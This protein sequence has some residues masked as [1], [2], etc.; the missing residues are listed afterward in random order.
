LTFAESLKLEKMNNFKQAIT[1][2]A[3]FCGM[4]VMAQQSVI[5]GIVIDDAT[6]ESLIGVAVVI[7]GTTIGDATDLE[8][9]FEIKAEPGTY[10]L[11]VAFISFAK[12]NISDVVVKS[13][14]VTALG[15]IRLKSASELLQEFVVTAKAVKNTEA[16]MVTMKQNSTSLMDGISA[17]SFKKVGDSDAAS[18]VT[19]VTGVSVQ[20]GKYVY[21]RGLGDRYTKTTLNGMDLPGLDPDRNSV[22]MDIFPTNV[23]DN[24]VV[25]KSFTADLPADFTG[26]AVNIELKDFPEE[27]IMTAGISTSYNPVMNLN[28][29]Y[30]TYNGG[31]TD[32]LGFDDG[33]RDIPT[34][35]QTDIPQYADPEVIGNPNSA[36]SQEFQTTLRSFDK[37]MGG[38]RTTSGLNGGFNFTYANKLK[39]KDKYAIG[40][41]LALNYQNTTEYYEGAEF[42]LYGKQAGATN[43]EL[44][45]LQ[46]Q[47]GDYGVNNVLLGGT[48]GLAIKSD[49]SKLRF[50]L[51]HLQNGESQAGIFD[52]RATDVGTTFLAKQYNLQYSERSLTNLLING[53]HELA[54]KWSLDWKVAPTKSSI[55]DP[56]IRF[57]RFQVDENT[58]EVSDR[59]TTEV[60]FPERIW[61]FLT[62]YNVSSRV[63]FNKDYKFKDRDAKFKVGAKYTYKTRNYTIQGFQINPGRDLDLNGDP[64]QLFNEEHLYSADNIQG[65]YHTPTFIPR[66]PNKYDSYVH[67]LGVYV[68]NEFNVTDELKAII[69]VRAEKYDQFYTGTNQNGSIVLNK[70]KVLG[71]FDLFPTANFIYAVNKKQNIRASYSRTIARPSF[72]EM[73]YAEIIDPITGRAFGGGLFEERNDLTGEVY[74]NGDLHS[75]KINNFDLRW[76]MFPSIGQTISVSAF[77][78]SFNDPIEIVQYVSDPGLFQARNVGDASVVGTEFEVIQSLDVLS[79]KLDKF[80]FNAN[81]TYTISS[82]TMSPSELRSRRI[83]AKEGEEVGV[84]RA[85]AGQ[86][87]YVINVGLSYTNK[88]KGL[89]ANASYNVQGQTLEFVGFGNRTDVYSVPFHSL[90]FKAGKTFGKDEKMSLS[91]KVSNIL[92]DD[93]TKVFKA[94]E[95]QDQIFSRLLPQRTFGL[96][97]SYK[98]H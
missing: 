75:T 20:G 81:A 39:A 38:F 60:G 4:Q 29:D 6:G 92:N 68:S 89:Q 51:L 74:W 14:E 71:D 61:R 1:I 35:K 32:F 17:A 19:R 82:I 63:D 54:N 36:R 9:Q 88:E 73:S 3:I 43:Y 77:Y 85:M 45:P 50:N 40:Y 27:K 25:S 93:K 16:A 98:F 30:I 76:E 59:I 55:N 87:P 2:V 12:L 28:S 94:Y 56:D 7:E 18:A 31:K 5:R 95:A 91:F 23:I 97:F 47:K 84:T 48:A 41:S 33:S 78:K 72:K 34:D 22:Q 62:E 46:T 86:A 58:G 21:V 83:T 96:S 79:E 70:D 65:V 24:I 42:N 69:G 57:M 52:Y 66:N 10:N 26:G 64:N 90:N 80:K 49:K 8:G 37:Q 11:V 15:T 53:Q 44:T 67:H 13:G